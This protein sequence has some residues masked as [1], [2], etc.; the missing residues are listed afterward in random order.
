ME[1]LRL[2]AES[3]KNLEYKPFNKDYFYSQAAT[4]YVIINAP[5]TGTDYPLRVFHKLPVGEN[6]Y[7]VKIDERSGNNG[8][9]HSAL[10]IE[11]KESTAGT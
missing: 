6:E 1:E 5:E 11:S 3:N 7:W 2:M 8:T 9:G 10:H 4:D